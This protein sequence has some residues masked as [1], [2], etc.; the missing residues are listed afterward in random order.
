MRKIRFCPWKYPTDYRMKKIFKIYQ[1]LQIPEP[2]LFTFKKAPK[3]INSVERS[4]WDI[5][6]LKMPF[7]EGNA[8][9]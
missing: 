9:T 8:G 6:G 4:G 7:A 5:S 1:K 3:G 2:R